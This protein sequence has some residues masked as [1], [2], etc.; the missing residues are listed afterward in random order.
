MCHVYIRITH[1]LEPVH[2]VGL[3]FGGEGGEGRGQANFLS[4]LPNVLRPS[5]TRLTNR[6]LQFPTSAKPTELVLR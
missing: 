3:V 1:E 5:T 4:V 2:G 6:L